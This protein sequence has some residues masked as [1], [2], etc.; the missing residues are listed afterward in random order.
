MPELSSLA[1]ATAQQILLLVQVLPII[2][3]DLTQEDFTADHQAYVTAMD[4]GNWRAKRVFRSVLY[5]SSYIQKMHKPSLLTDD[6]DAI[7]HDII[8]HH[9][10]MTKVT[11]ND[12]DSRSI[13]HTCLITCTLM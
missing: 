13:L 12:Y 1:T 9:V 5:L 6:I 10:A 8:Q 2:F 4:R 11:W 3:S 7:H